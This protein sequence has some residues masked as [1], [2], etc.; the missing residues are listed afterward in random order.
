MCLWPLGSHSSISFGISFVLLLRCWLCGMRRKTWI[1]LYLERTNTRMP[2]FCT[3]NWGLRTKIN[4]RNREI[5]PCIRTYHQTTQWW[6]RRAL[7]QR[8]ICP[9]SISIVSYYCQRCKHEPGSI[10]TAWKCEF[11]FISR[12]GNSSKKRKIFR[13]DFRRLAQTVYYI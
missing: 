4:K 1:V 12:V 7:F 5:C 13:P 8:V 6:C 11:C 9:S 10:I 3:F 2:M